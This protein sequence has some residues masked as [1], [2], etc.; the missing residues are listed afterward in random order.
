MLESKKNQKADLERF[1]GMFFNIGLVLSLSAFIFLFEANFRSSQGE[2]TLKSGMSDFE[3]LMDIPLS[4]QPP[5]P[6]P[7]Q[8]VRSINLISIPDFQ[9]IEE[10]LDIQLD[11]DITQDSK[12]EDLAYTDGTAEIEFEEEEV[13]EIFTIV[14]FQPTPKGG[15]EEFYRYVSENLVYPQRALRMGIEGKVFIQFIVGKDGRISD[16]IVVKGINEE[17]DKEAIRVLLNAPP[18][19]PGKQRGRPVNVRMVIPINY[20]ILSN[21]LEN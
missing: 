12:I 18:W 16:P 20:K 3:E 19:N 2:L 10:D 6:P 15:Y 4:E 8:Q 9:E 17:C 1:R 5:P 7:K 13:E 11:I 21:T 14:E